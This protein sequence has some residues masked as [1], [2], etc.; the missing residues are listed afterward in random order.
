MTNPVG[1]RFWS[2]LCPCCSVIIFQLPFLCQ[3]QSLVANLCKFDVCFVPCLVA[4]VICREWLSS[5]VIVFLYMWFL[6]FPT[7]EWQQVPVLF[8]T[9]IPLGEISIQLFDICWYLEMV[10]VVVEEFLDHTLW[11]WLDRIENC[12]T[13]LSYVHLIWMSCSPLAYLTYLLSSL[14]FI[15]TMIYKSAR[16]LF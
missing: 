6:C 10:V 8:I 16:W 13:M 4:A 5:C 15:H 7:N 12:I 2:I 1:V 3:I 14:F 9:V 11:L